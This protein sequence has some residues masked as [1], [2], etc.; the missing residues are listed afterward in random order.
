MGRAVSRIAVVGAGLAGLTV[1]RGLRERG[2]QV[3]VFDKGRV[4]GGRMATRVSGEL[5]F[6]HGA[7]YFTA[8]DPGFQ[9]WLAPSL[10]SGTVAE[11]KPRVLT[12][13]AGEPPYKRDWFEPHYVAVPGMNAWAAEL[14]QGLDVRSL[15]RIESLQRSP[16]GGWQLDDQGV[17]EEVVLALP[18]PQT[19]ALLPDD[20]PGRS[21]IAAVEMLGCYAW[22]LSFA[23]KPSLH[24][25]AAQVRDSPLGWL[26]WSH[27]RP[28]RSTAP[29]LLL[30]SDNQWAQKRIDHALADIESELLPELTRLTGLQG[31]SGS[32]GHRWRYAATEKPLG[33]TH[34]R[35]PGL[36]L[37]VCGDWC[38]GNRVEAA[39][40]SAQGLL[41]SWD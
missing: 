26:C 12:F 6:D 29:A 25:D 19:L 23:K 39:Y 3:V 38:I 15:T 18:A 30:L 37:S 40:L 34:L 27:S 32:Q 9:R 2:H 21:A 7:Q 28:G 41:Q 4:P 17:F 35:P 22:M 20:V 33:R 13:R 31:W 14:A 16:Q 1:A 5:T 36:G 10:A 8:R 11:W 24:W